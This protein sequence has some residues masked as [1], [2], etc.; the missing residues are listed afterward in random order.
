MIVAITMVAMI[1]QTLTFVVMI[2]EILKYRNEGM[3]SWLEMPDS[4]RFIF[5]NM[6]NCN[7]VSPWDI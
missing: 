7:A 5:P 2:E 4:S 6:S 1:F 3:F